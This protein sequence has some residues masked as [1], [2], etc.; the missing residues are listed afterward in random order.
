MTSRILER[1]KTS[2]RTDDNPESIKLRLDTYVKETLPVVERFKQ[3]GNCISVNA[4]QPREEVYKQL[5]EKMD[6][7]GIYPPD[8][9]EVLFVLG[10]PGSGKGT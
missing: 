2:G 1:A 3:A 7:E 10:G 5:K 6:E 9:A 8:P 4:E